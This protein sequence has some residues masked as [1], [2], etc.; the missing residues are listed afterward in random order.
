MDRYVDILIER[1][2]MVKKW[3]GYATRIAIAVKSI[4][5]DARIYIFGSV[6]KGEAVGGSDVDIL[7]ASSN[8]PK[9]NVERAGIKVRIEDAANLPPYHPFELHLVDEQEMEWYVRRVKDLK[10]Y[11]PTESDF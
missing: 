2:E 10:E 7:I 3:D 1:S 8:M 4:L 11:K 9:S 6:L 5:P